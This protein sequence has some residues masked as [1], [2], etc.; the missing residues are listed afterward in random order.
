MQ[1]RINQARKGRRGFTLIELL[2]VVL[3]LGV[4]LAIAIP[5][6]LGSVRNAGTR[7]VQSNLKII[8]NAAQAYRVKNGTYPAD[9]ATLIGANGG[10]LTVLPTG[11]ATTTYSLVGTGTTE[12]V[13]TATEG[14]NDSFG[15]V[16]TGE[17]A[18]FTMSTGAF[19]S[20]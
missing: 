16:A 19:V 11:P 3:I 10:D 9:A 15:T 12:C 1:T 17:T 14:G 7:T 13:V 2:V 18:T 8:G 4:L 20:P 5:L 6:Y